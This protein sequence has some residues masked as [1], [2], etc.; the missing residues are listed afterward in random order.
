MKKLQSVLLAGAFLFTATLSKAQSAEDIVKKHN[1]AIGGT[2]NWSKITSIKK[3]GSMNMMGMDMACTYTILKGKGFRQDFNVMG[4]E[5]Y[6]IMTPT[7]GWMFIP[8][9]GHT[10]PEAM[11]EEALKDVAE[12]LDFQDGIMLASEKK[13]PIELVGQEDIDGNSCFKLKVTDADKSETTYFVDSK[14]FYTVRETGVANVQGQDM[15]VTKN[16]S[17]YKKLP[18]GIVVAM[19]EDAGESGATTFTK[20]EVNTIKDESIFKP[21]AK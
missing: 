15:E 18:E 11:P 13:Y 21:A 4:S 3:E 6:V 16:I 20:I 7:A 5:C 2:K 8:P 10:K 9:Q 17:D 19:K 14:T 12:A 1:E